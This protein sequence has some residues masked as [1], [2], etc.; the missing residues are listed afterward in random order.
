MRRSHVAPTAIAATQAMTLISPSG[1]AKAITTRR[2]AHSRPKMAATAVERLSIIVAPTPRRRVFLCL[3]LLL[4]QGETLLFR[5]RAKASQGS[6]SRTVSDS[7]AQNG[8]LRPFLRQIGTFARR[9]QT[10]I[11]GDRQL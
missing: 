7:G 2:P 1:M 6:R 9:S 5:P 8:V 10:R 3:A 4:S 11:D